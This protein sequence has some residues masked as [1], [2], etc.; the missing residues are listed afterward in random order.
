MVWSA[1]CVLGKGQGVFPVSEGRRPSEVM[2][3]EPEMTGSWRKA[4]AASLWEI[5]KVKAGFLLLA[6]RVSAS[7]KAMAKIT[8]PRTNRSLFFFFFAF[9][10]MVTFFV[11]TTALSLQRKI[12]LRPN[13]ETPD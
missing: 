9:C 13:G 8:S 3:T 6:E 1:V 7:D 2:H 5:V 11:G 10:S 4:P 12:T